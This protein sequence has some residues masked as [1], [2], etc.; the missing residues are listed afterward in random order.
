MR[1]TRDCELRERTA[2]HRPSPSSLYPLMPWPRAAGQRGFLF[3]FLRAAG[4]AIPLLSPVS[5][6]AS[7]QAAGRGVWV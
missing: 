3:L 5:C 2:P 6:A 1:P 4:D 7:C